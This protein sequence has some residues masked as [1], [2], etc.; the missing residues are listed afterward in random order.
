METSPVEMGKEKEEARRKKACARSRQWYAANRKKVLSQQKQY[1]KDNPDKVRVT[2]RK[3]WS[4]GKNPKVRL[5]RVLARYQEFMGCELCGQRGPAEMFDFHHIDSRTKNFALNTNA[6]SKYTCEEILSE[7]EKCMCLDAVCH[8][9][10]G[11]TIPRIVDSAIQA[12]ETDR[13]VPPESS[14]VEMAHDRPD[15]PTVQ[16]GLRQALLDFA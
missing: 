14:S 8:R 13:E 11:V 9:L 10:V 1:R 7:F 2:H 6:V 5:F 16:G 4:H 12:A 3:R 15:V